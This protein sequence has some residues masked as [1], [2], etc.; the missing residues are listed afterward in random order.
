[1]IFH[2]YVKLPEGISFHSGPGLSVGAHHRSRPPPL[3]APRPC[4]RHVELAAAGGD[5]GDGGCDWVTPGDWVTSAYQPSKPGIPV[6]SWDEPVLINIIRSKGWIFSQQPGIQP[7]QY[8]QAD[9]RMMFCIKYIHPQHW[10]KKPGWT[11]A[12]LLNRYRC[13][14][15]YF[16]PTLY[17]WFGNVSLWYFSVFV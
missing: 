13:S 17:P 7:A 12:K 3:A 6:K 2:S 14:M 4:R 9:L 1:M 16:S 15:Q 11:V 8:F 5:A 10:P